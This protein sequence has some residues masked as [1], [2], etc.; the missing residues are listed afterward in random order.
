[1]TWHN[2]SHDRTWSTPR[3]TS[4]RRLQACLQRQLSAGSPPVARPPYPD[5]RRRL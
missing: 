2:E 4:P 3:G 1:M 5:S